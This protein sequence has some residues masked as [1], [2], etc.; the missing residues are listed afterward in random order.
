MY[1]EEFLRLLVEQGSRSGESTRL[2]PNWPGFKSWRQRHM[3]VE[4]VVGS[5]LCSERFFLGYPGFSLSSKTNT[6]KFYFNLERT[7]T[8]KRGVKKITTIYNYFE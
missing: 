2:P 5:L 7:D 3:W 8:F 4:F 1:F 6:S